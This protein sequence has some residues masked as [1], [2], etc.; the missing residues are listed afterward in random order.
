MRT[1]WKFGYSSHDYLLCVISICLT[2]IKCR[3]IF[4]AIKS[5]KPETIIRHMYHLWRIHAD[6]HNYI[7]FDSLDGTAHTKNFCTHKWRK[8]P[9][10]FL[11]LFTNKSNRKKAPPVI[12]KC[13]IYRSLVAIVRFV[14]DLACTAIPAVSVSKSVTNWWRFRKT[15]RYQYL[16]DSNDILFAGWCVVA[17][18]VIRPFCGEASLTVEAMRR[19]ASLV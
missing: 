3:L 9:Y 4:V 10:S 1:Y 19:K 15:L 2:K 14:V 16:S 7:R 18:N 6:H 11:V 12:G 17:T 13:T 8:P 5:H